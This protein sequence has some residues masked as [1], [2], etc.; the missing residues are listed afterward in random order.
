[1]RILPII[2]IA[3]TLSSLCAGTLPADF[4]FEPAGNERTSFISQWKEYEEN[5]ARQELENQGLVDASLPNASPA[6]QEDKEAGHSFLKKCRQLL[7]QAF[8]FLST[9]KE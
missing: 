8:A 7:A 3:S 1:M 6:A 5:K 2:M 4:H 9:K